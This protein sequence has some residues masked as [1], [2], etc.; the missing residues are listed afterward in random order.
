MAPVPKGRVL[1]GED[2]AQNV[3]DG[4][5]HGTDQNFTLGNAAV[6]AGITTATNP[7]LQNLGNGYYQLNWKTPSGYARSCK[8][9]RLDLGEGSGARTAP[10][11]G[12]RTSAAAM[13]PSV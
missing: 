9:M 7:N 12:S 2:I 13:R 5:A 8:L 10:V 3:V 6:A 1:C 11:S 4:D